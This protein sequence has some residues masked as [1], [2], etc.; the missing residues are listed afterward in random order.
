MIQK[1]TPSET[2][3][4]RVALGAILLFI[5]GVGTG[6]AGS[7]LV[8]SPSSA[9]LSRESPI[10][11][12]ATAEVYQGVLGST[13][14]YQGWCVSGAGLTVPAQDVGV[15]TSL[16]GTDTPVPLPSV[17]VEVSGRPVIALRGTAIVYR[18]L[19]G[20]SAGADVAMLQGALADAGLYT[21]PLDGDYGPGTA[22]A[23]EALYENL[24][25]NPPN[26]SAT[27]VD[28]RLALAQVELAQRNVDDLVAA[29]ADAA[30]LAVSRAE[31]AKARQSAE[32]VADSVLTPFPMTELM[33]VAG[34][35]Y[36][37]H[38]PS[39]IVGSPL[40]E[41]VITLVPADVTGVRLAVARSTAIALA[42]GD[43]VE[44]ILAGGTGS[45]VT[46]DVTWIA[47]EVGAAG[48]EERFDANTPV[49]DGMVGVEV[50]LRA[51]VD[52]VTGGAVTVHIDVSA[53]S[54][55]GLIVPVS[56]VRTFADGT[57]A[58]SVL[59]AGV[60]DS[61]QMR[62]VG[63]VVLETRDG[64]ALVSSI[65]LQAGDSVVIQ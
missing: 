53:R 40:T 5:V 41:G 2:R 44:V 36:V 32:V 21:G 49:L 45:M 17:L 57:T 27:S 34:D 59:T 37:L 61:L 35:G 63:V 15:I 13:V 24:G 51:P 11:P 42:E 8:Q 55:E 30:E 48:S 12:P 64:R 39:A 65:E 62:D 20:G 22:Q 14:Q 3:R 31:L 6:L 29:S 18:D 10:L 52:C 25:Y 38:Q 58:V 7:Q 33:Y 54:Q 50:A 56:A 23:V 26:A 43:E 28:L 9:A 19:V 46:G 1:K 16:F 47:S 4:F 60:S